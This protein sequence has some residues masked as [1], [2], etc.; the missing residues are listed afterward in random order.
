M[1]TGAFGRDDNDRVG[2]NLEDREAAEP[3]AQQLLDEVLRETLSVVSD[4]DPL[5][6]EDLRKLIDV[7]HR[8]GDKIQEAGVFDLVQCLLGMRFGGLAKNKSHWDNVALKI[9]HCLL[10]D[11]PSEERLRRFWTRLYEAAG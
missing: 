4:S 11:P 9:T 2:E 10:E 1:S 3:G 7:V 8:H 5:S 6:A